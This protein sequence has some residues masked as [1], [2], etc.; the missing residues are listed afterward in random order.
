MS[1]KRPAPSGE[2]AEEEVAPFPRGG[3]SILTPLEERRLKLQA[4]ADFE[5]EG[6]AAEPR[7]KKKKKSV[8]DASDD[9]EDVC[10]QPRQ[11][12]LAC[13]TQI[14]KI[15]EICIPNYC[16]Y[17]HAHRYEYTCVSAVETCACSEFSW[18]E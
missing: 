8:A 4:Q 18:I 13:P 12:R 15:S 6:G 11:P 10:C 1:K 9:P 16:A 3:A 14:S 5:R 7:K 17:R 2:A